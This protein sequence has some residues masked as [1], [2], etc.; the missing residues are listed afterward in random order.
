MSL[1]PRS[2]TGNH[3][4]SKQV[5]DSCPA[6]YTERGAFKVGDFSGIIKDYW[7]DCDPVLPICQQIGIINELPKSIVS[8]YFHLLQLLHEWLFF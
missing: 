6:H 2:V 5:C 1:A 7:R 3:E 4:T 8:I